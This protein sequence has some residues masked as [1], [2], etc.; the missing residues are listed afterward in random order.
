MGNG[1][2]ALFDE[3]L[4]HLLATG[5]FE[6]DG[7]LVAFDIG[8]GAIAELEMKDAFTH[9]E[10]GSVTPQIDRTGDQITLNSERAAALA[11]C[12]L[13]AGALPARRF[14]D[15]LERIGLVEAG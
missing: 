11:A 8:D 2:S 13:R 3:A 7:Q 12:L 14:V 1:G 15:A 9:G 6:V 10:G 5:L 4:Q